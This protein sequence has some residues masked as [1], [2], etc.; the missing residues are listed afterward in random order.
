[1]RGQ[2]LWA[3][4]GCI[5]LGAVLLSGCQTQ[6]TASNKQA[7]FRRM[8]SDTIQSMD[9]SKS[10]DAISG[11]VLVDTMDGF[12]RYTG[13][14]L[15]PAIATKIAKPTNG[16]KTYTIHLKKGAK[17]ANGQQVTAQDFVYGWRRSVDPITK[18][19]YAYLFNNIVNAKA[20]IAGKKNPKTLGI[21]AKNKTTV[22]IRLTEPTPYF[23]GLLTTAAFFPQ[24]AKF[25]EKVGA[26]YGTQ[27]K[28]TLSNGP[29]ILKQWDGDA[30]TWTEVKNKHYWQAK[31]VRLDKISVR[32]VKN[33]N[34]ALKLY[35]QNKLDDIVL[36]GQSAQRT[37]ND[38]NFKRQT[39][40]RTIF[41]ELNQQTIPA[42]KNE[43]IRQA[44]S[45]AIN[46]TELVHKVLG[47]GSLVAHNVTP[48]GLMRH[49]TTGVDFAKA[50]TAK[51]SSATKYN[52]KKAQQ[53]FA[54]GLKEL[55]LTHLDVTLLG[56]NTQSAIRTSQYLKSAWE[57]NLPGFKVTT[58]NVPLKTR[59]SRSQSGQFDMVVSAWSADYPDAISFLDL[60]TTDN[61]YNNGKWHNAAYDAFIQKSKTTDALDPAKRF[62]DLQQAQAILTSSQ[63][64]L[65]L[66]Q[67]VEAHLIHPKV[68][69]LPY[70]PANNYNYAVTYLKTK[71]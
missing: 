54:A 53:L 43:K 48:T 68:K 25:I 42:F 18:A 52:V 58:Q 21:T 57:T 62:A 39:Q 40:S 67:R 37:K 38:A 65:P 35:Q 13:Q 26:L 56:E 46:R 60:F 31:R 50:A 17:W 63:G 4:L 24:N 49:P 45:L 16:G 3:L 32:V 51:D 29:F 10:T 64:V 61:S 47:D 59:L 23:N 14:K 41:T 22:Q 12:Y 28:Y 33:S 7:V 9:P 34:K 70:S 5:F 55:G 44:L 71:S 19:R 8:E 27:A 30:K 36:T 2:R 69:N 20:I 6:G 1:M 11:Q 15:K 66:Y